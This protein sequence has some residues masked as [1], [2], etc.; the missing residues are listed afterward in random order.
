MKKNIRF[1]ASVL[2]LFLFQTGFTQTPDGYK[3]WN[4]ATDSL[5][6]LE[7]QAWPHE[8][9]SFYDRLPAKAEPSV[10]H[11]V[12]E[13][14]R[15]SA[16]LKLRF[17]TDADEIIVKYK[18]TGSLQMPHMPATGVSGVDLYIK[19][20]D[21]KW[22]WGAGKYSF[23]DTIVYRFKDLIAN[24]QHVS[25]REYSLYLPLYN[26]VSWMEITVPEKSLFKP[27]PARRDKPVL[28]Y[29]T[30]IAQGGCASR[31]GLAWTALLERKLD[32]PLINLSFSGNGRLDQEVLDLIAEVDAKIY[33]LD[34]LPNM[35]APAFTTAELKKRVVH[36]I[37][38]LQTKR[39]GIP[40]LLTDHA[41]YTNEASSTVRQKQY[42]N[43]NTALHEVF[44][45]L[46]ST[47]YKN[48]YRLT[49]EEIG[50]DIESTVDGIHPNDIGMMQYAVAY[51]KKIGSIL[52]E[53]AGSISTT[54][55]ITQR[56]DA[57]T[58]DWET[59]HNEVLAFNQDHSPALVF[60]GNSITHYWGGL[61]LAQRIWGA[62]SWKKY[63][64]PRN[65]ENLGYG[66]DRIENVLWRIYHGELDGI[67]PKQ[68][69]MMIGTNNLEL[70]SDK[71]II[72]GLR[73]LMQAIQEK[74]PASQILLLG[75]LPRRNMEKR[76]SAL[77]TQIA[78][79]KFNAKVHYA[80]AGRL[81]LKPD[82]KIDESLFSDGLH[83]NEAGYE[84]FGK[85]IVSHLTP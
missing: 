27:L 62:G 66:W 14:S 30:S 60:I 72:E 15:N 35:V 56:R 44:D 68:I 74:Q 33:V 49:K 4:P 1:V 70:N 24:D 45:S 81:F 11:A 80:D 71:E 50:L 3:S 78:A 37:Q 69:V 58:Y 52:N 18:V 84:R 32:R 85:F 16:G 77:N 23:G 20:I 7:G 79:I 63:F 67:H 8:G 51:A 82:K 38:L 29:G 65:A 43:A 75:I 5:S 59:R 57:A 83:P 10:R 40:I 2:A 55:P 26:S 17:I 76:V 6:V 61:P 12:W 42:Q 28:I 73:F 36:A 25:N 54:I 9:K 64:E 53:P 47:G 22:L 13:L 39:P 48:I 34:C 41:G 21:G 31:P 46:V 19:T